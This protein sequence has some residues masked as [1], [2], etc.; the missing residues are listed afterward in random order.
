[1]VQADQQGQQQAGGQAAVQPF[2]AFAGTD[3]HGQLA[4]TKTL[5]AEVGTDVGGPHQQHH[6]EDQAVALRPLLEQQ[7]ALPGRQQDQQTEQQTHRQRLP[8]PTA[9]RI[10]EHQTDRRQPPEHRQRQQR[11]GQLW[12]LVQPQQQQRHSRGI[13][14]SQRLRLET[15]EARPLPGTQADD[16]RDEQGKPATLQQEEATQGDGQQ[17]QGGDDALFQHVGFRCSAATCSLVLPNRRWRRAKSASAV[18]MA[19]CLKSGQ[20]SSEKYSSA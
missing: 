13:T 8:G 19:S 17:A 11:T 6:R 20:S 16:G 5:A 2:P 9:G 4:P 15:G 14:D 3:L 12:Q 10:A 7:Q 18:R 1:M